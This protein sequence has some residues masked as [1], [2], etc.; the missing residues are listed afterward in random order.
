MTPFH[1]DTHFL[2]PCGLTSMNH[3][4]AS[5]TLFTTISRA[6]LDDDLGLSLMFAD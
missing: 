5:I 3:E 4:G 6:L 1:D 2:G